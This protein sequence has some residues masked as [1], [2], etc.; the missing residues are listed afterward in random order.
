[1][2][3]GIASMS[4]VAD[5][6][7]G[8]ARSLAE[9][10]LRNLA[11]V[12]AAGLV[13]A[14]SLTPGLDLAV[15]SMFYLGERQFLGE[16]V[17]LVRFIRF[18]LLS[19]YV[20][21]CIVVVIGLFATR[22]NPRGWA[23]LT[24]SQWLFFAVCL[25]VGPGIV[26]NLALKDQSGRARPREVVELGGQKQYSAAFARSNQCVRNCSF[27]SGEASSMFVM[28]FAAASVW[29]RRWRALAGAGLAAGGIAGLIR[30]MQGAHFL[31]DVVFAAVFMA[32]TVAL[33]QFIFD[34]IADSARSEGLAA[35]SRM[36]TP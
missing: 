4:N 11:L 3:G 20:G 15:A 27:V 22:I 17:K 33:I 19:A 30:M 25:G 13:V 6:G 26:A 12:A 28:F 23:S 10:P 29:R 18:I 36:P 5:F 7:A 14:A 24:F 31:T 21:A 34:A 32:M 35:A 1:M 8:R 16:G 9:P 2:P